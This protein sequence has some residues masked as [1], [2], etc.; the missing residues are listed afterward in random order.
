MVV[1]WPWYWWGFVYFIISS[2]NSCKTI[3]STMKVVQW[4]KED[5]YRW[6]L[7]THY[8]SFIHLLHEEYLSSIS[9]RC[10]DGSS[11]LPSQFVSSFPR[12]LSMWP[13]LL[14]DQL[15][16]FF[17]AVGQSLQK[18]W[19]LFYS[20][21]EIEFFPCVPLPGTVSPLSAIFALKP[22]FPVNFVA[23]FAGIPKELLLWFQQAPSS[24]HSNIKNL[25]NWG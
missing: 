12:T 22:V 17:D 13:H 10:G 21:Q 5:V 15:L 20:V 25:F 11:V 3:R 7:Q 24:K 19:M 16:L 8:L 1:K 23:Y 4:S 9:F 18:K 2:H 6:M 14:I